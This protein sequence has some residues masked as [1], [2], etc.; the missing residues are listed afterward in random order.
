MYKYPLW[1]APAARIMNYHI[2]SKI[3]HCLCRTKCHLPLELQWIRSFG[4]PLARRWII[5]HIECCHW[6]CPCGSLCSQKWSQFISKTIHKH[7]VHCGTTKNELNRVYAVGLRAYIC[8]CTHVW[9]RDRKKNRGK[10]VSS[11]C[12]FFLSIYM[13]IGDR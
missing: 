1:R 8:K 5:T 6:W 10:K 2:S 12:E 13:A 11:L 7:L 4:T 3:H 9:R